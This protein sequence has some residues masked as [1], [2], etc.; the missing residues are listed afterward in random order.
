VAAEVAHGIDAL[1]GETGQILHVDSLSGQPALLTRLAGAARAPMGGP[2]QIDGED[3]AAARL[4]CQ[5]KM[6]Q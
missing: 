4:W 6:T 1:H 2:G 3:S 5:A